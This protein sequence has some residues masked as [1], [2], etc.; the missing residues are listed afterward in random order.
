MKRG[1]RSVNVFGC[2]AISWARVFMAS[3]DLGHVIGRQG[4][5]AAAIRTL[6]ALAGER[7][8]RRVQVEFRDGPARGHDPRVE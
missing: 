7:D 3:G 8:D 4:R 1:V 5:T 2:A 6:A